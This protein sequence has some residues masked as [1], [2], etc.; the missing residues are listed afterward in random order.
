MLTGR[1]IGLFL[2]A[3][4]LVSAAAPPVAAQDKGP[5]NG[6]GRCNPA[7]APDSAMLAG[8]VAKPDS[9]PRH[10]DSDVTIA[11]GA[12]RLATSDDQFKNYGGHIRRVAVKALIDTVGHVVPG[13]V[14]ITSSSSGQLS[15]AVCDAMSQMRFR[16]AKKSG[17]VVLAQYADHLEFIS[18]SATSTDRGPQSQSSV[19]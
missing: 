7:T 15:V 12:F 8:V 17:A 10:L 3:V 6:I 13:S 16:P 1:Q 11:Q 5:W 2:G 19:R 4:M 18:T 9:K 14:E